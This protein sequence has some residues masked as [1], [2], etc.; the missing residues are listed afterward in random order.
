GVDEHLNRHEALADDQRKRKA[1]KLPASS[2]ARGA[3][4]RAVLSRLR[5]SGGLYGGIFCQNRAVT[6][7]SCLWSGA[8]PTTSRCRTLGPPTWFEEIDRPSADDQPG[9]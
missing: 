7:L 8:G 9:W 2:F 3:S 6:H 5:L 4:K 1:E